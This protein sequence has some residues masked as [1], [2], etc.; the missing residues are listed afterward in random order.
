MVENSEVT[1][2]SGMAN[3]SIAIAPEE[4]FLAEPFDGPSANL[5]AGKI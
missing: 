2:A 5:S 3:I 4:I 1:T